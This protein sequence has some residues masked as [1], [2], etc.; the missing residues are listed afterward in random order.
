M[1]G[2]HSAVLVHRVA[3]LLACYTW[4]K[5]LE[6]MT[7]TLS[8]EWTSNGRQQIIRGCHEESCILEGMGEPLYNSLAQ[9]SCLVGGV[10]GVAVAKVHGQRDCGV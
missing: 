8:Q 5:V 4:P 3:E 10:C 9:C 7:G 2:Q 1:C 6:V